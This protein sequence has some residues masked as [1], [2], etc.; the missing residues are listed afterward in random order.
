MKELVR[1]RTLLR[2]P[3]LIGVGSSLSPLH[4]LAEAYPSKAIRMVIPFPPGGPTDIVARPLAKLLGDA[5]RQQVF[6][7]NRG[8]AGG[9][10]GASNVATSKPDG[11]TLLMG[12]VGTSAINP[13]LYKNLPYDPVVDFT[14][15]ASV[16]SAPVAVVVNPSAGIASIAELIAKAKT[17]PDDLTYGS[18]GNGTPGHLAGAMFCAAAGIK[19]RHVPY[20]GSAPGIVDLLG[21]Q[22]PIMFDP[23][24]SVLAHVQAGKLKP[25]GITSRSRTKVLPDVPTV[26]ESIPDFEMTAW[27]AVYGPAHLPANISSLL[28]AEIRR[29]VSSPDFDA[30]LGNLGVQPLDVPLAELQKK[31]LAKWGAAVRTAGVILE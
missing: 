14:P 8:G 21:G 1:R 27:W 17:R 5:L 3:F 28:V 19:M 16:A 6:I 23:L 25:L 24:Q 20:K 2:L 29:I 13:H 4:V 22:I 10:V 11:Y 7:D 9:S 15:L 30:G 31:E 12:T 26:S 18:A